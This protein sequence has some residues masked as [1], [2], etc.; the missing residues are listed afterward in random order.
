MT[1]SG[2]LA[3]S[4]EQRD[5]STPDVR[6][7]S[8]S[9]A[10]AQIQTDIERDLFVSAAASM[11]LGGERGRLFRLSLRMTKVWMSSSLAPSKIVRLA[12]LAPDFVRKPETSWSRSSG[13]RMPCAR[14]RAR[15]CLRALDIGKDQF[16]IE[17]E[18]AGEPFEILPTARFESAAPQ[19]H[20]RYFLKRGAHLDRQSDQVDEAQRVFLVITCAHGEAGNIRDCTANSGSCG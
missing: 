13:V 20:R 3:A 17:M 15:K 9:A 11:D 16:A 7:S 2:Y 18:R 8:V 6:L 14:E 5:P 10:C 1:A 4:F 12:S 19:F